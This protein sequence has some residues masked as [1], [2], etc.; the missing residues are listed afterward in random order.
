MLEINGESNAQT[1][2]LKRKP[3][4][5]LENRL[6]QKRRRMVK[7]PSAENRYDK[8]DHLPS[9]QRN[10]SQNRCRME[11]CMLKS[12]FF[13]LKCKVYLCI[14]EKKNCFANFHNQ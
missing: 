11:G 13:C 1:K 7:K 14:K 3:D 4:D 5:L 8:I 10:T 2:S 9:T 6:N 12:N